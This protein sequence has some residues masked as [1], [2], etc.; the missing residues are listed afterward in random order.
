[1]DNTPPALPRPTTANDLARIKTAFDPQISPDGTRVAYVVKKIDLEKNRYESR[2]WTVAV[3][4]PH[5]TR[6]WTFGIGDNGK[7]GGESS[8]RWSPDGARL[9]FTSAREGKRGQI[10]LLPT[11]GG[12]E[13]ERVTDLG[14]GSLGPIRWS[15]DGN[16]IAFTFRPQDAAWGEEAAEERKKSDKSTPAREITRLHFREEGA[17]FLPSARM[18]LYVLDIATRQ[19]APL[20]GEDFDVDGFCWSPDGARIAFVR[21]TA[22]DPDLAPNAEEIFVMNAAPHGGDATTSEPTKLNA[23]LGP[24]QNLAWSPDGKHI[25]YL[26]HANATEVWGVTNSHLWVLTL[27]EN[28]GESVARD[29]TPDWDV[30]FGNTT[31][32]DVTG[33]GESG[34]VWAE[35]GAS[36]LALVSQN[37][38]VEVYRLS[39][40]TNEP[41]RRVTEGVHVVEGF[42]ADAQA[43]NLALLVA[44]PTDA[45]DV[46]VL[47]SGSSFFKRLTRLNEALFGELDL[48][49]ARYFEAQSP[50]GHTVP[51]FALLPP[52]YDRN[53]SPRPVVLYIHGG[54]HLMYGHALFHDYQV[55]AAQGYV[56]LFPNP[57]GSKGYG[58]AW[59]GA[60]K[61]NWGEPAQADCLA[62]LDYAIGEGWAD[63]A[64][65]G[66][67]GGSYGGYLTAWMM[68]HS[69]G[70][71]R[72]G[73]A[74][75]G[76]YN[77]V[78][79][80]GTCDF[81]WRDDRSYFN[82][83]ATNDTE[84]YRRNSPLT[85]VNDITAPL[86]LIHSEGD[87]RCP[88][89]QADQL[90]AALKR[91]GRDVI[92]LRYGTES[93]HG[94]TR[95][96]PPDLR[97][98]RQ[99]RIIAF[100]DRHLRV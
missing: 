45:G 46:Y 13:A 51:C 5:D 27:G 92:Y 42:T 80:A 23:P 55:L 66:V 6:Q 72:A 70:R 38:T 40:H 11:N 49:A 17:G 97:I 86:L 63:T 28:G 68:A 37:A 34:P 31:L 81:V 24:K 94:L 87:L 53:P 77:L 2:I 43:D 61:G 89:E 35:G 82:A 7:S 84:D 39:L 25:A 90:F 65:A 12:G 73:V 26:G 50:E 16:R 3:A 47:P 71:F 48:P 1:L 44:Q 91:L 36:L 19:V 64:R 95:N 10:Y 98:D 83:N 99:N 69:S 54:P 33:S 100:F 41:P 59:T 75:R 76:V 30:T 93:N 32:G 4:A 88:I 79:M 62:C 52:G 22:S 74:E 15:P 56:V 57:R 96:G 14:Q 20:T 18:R 9:A 60:I 58:E 78:S 8:P 21:N 67:I 85:Y 29:L